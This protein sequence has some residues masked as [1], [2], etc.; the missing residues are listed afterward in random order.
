MKSNNYT[1]LLLRI[2]FGLICSGLATNTLADAKA[3]ILTFAVPVQI[4]K[5]DP[6]GTL[7]AHTKAILP[8][9]YEPLIIVNPAQMLQPA[10]AKSWSIDNEQQA[11]TITLQKAHHFSD[12]SEVTAAD[13]IKSFDR[14]CS[15]ESKA[16]G[17]LRGLKGCHGLSKGTKPEIEQIGKYKVKLHISN[18]PTTFLYQ[19]SSPSTVIVKEISSRKLIGSGAYTIAQQN[20]Q[21]ITLKPNPYYFDKTNIANDGLKFTMVPGDDLA[22]ELESD[23]FDGALMFRQESLA[24]LTTKNYKLIKS[25]PNITEILVLNNQTFPFNQPIL[26]NA[27]ANEIY[28]TFD[29]SCATGAHQA[30]GVI[31]YGMAGSISN[32]KP[33]KLKEISPIA[34]FEK[35]PEL[36]H[37]N[38]KITVHVLND[39]K[40]NCISQKIRTAGKKY[41]LNIQFKYHNNYHALLKS[42]HQHTLD[43]FI[44]LYVFKNRDAYR[45]LEY[46]SGS[47]ENHANIKD[48]K[49][50]EMLNEAIASP[51]SHGR[52]QMY[53]QIDQYLQENS[54]VIPLFYMDHGN[55]IKKCVT[56]IANDF[57]FDPFYQLP[58][59]SKAKDRIN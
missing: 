56:G 25:N 51:S 23:K 21:S 29:K 17:E 35:I 39:I 59:L 6:M 36:A 10:L 34:V 45:I 57:V 37:G 43:A 18:N 33:D 53:K 11:I 3:D 32:M 2:I 24:N 1:K 20:Q 55:L 42:Y 38:T 19:L 49:I 46:L 31:P 52:F 48:A 15:K 41:H 4:N 16:L 40:N 58:K 13:A 30:F 5:L 50:D 44:D 7:N 12:G 54:I 8:L 47:A 14:L 26:R 9:V 22:K 28:N 27:L